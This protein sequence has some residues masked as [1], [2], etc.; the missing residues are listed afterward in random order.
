MLETLRLGAIGVLSIYAL[1]ST[2][3]VLFF[4]FRAA[5]NFL[6]ALKSR[7]EDASWLD[8]ASWFRR[9]GYTRDGY[10]NLAETAGDVG[11]GVLVILPWGVLLYL[12]GL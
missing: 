5:F 11:K 8:P 7:A 6:V 10:E 1:A 12:A 4:M 2:P 9:R 3:F